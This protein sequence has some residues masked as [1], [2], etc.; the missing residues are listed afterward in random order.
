M[1]NGKLERRIKALEQE[2]DKL[3]R[4]YE[5]SLTRV[6]LLVDLLLVELKLEVFMTEP[7][8]PKTIPGKPS[9]LALRPVIADASTAPRRKR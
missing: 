1:F 7:V 3:R 6:G 8:P 2:R 9:R 5:D 4:N